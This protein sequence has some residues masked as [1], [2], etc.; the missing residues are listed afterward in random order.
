MSATVIDQDEERR[1]FDYL[2]TFLFAKKELQK[3]V[4]LPRCENIRELWNYGIEGGIIDGI[5]WIW[6]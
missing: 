3:W 1:H 6:D 4:D 2:N 5:A